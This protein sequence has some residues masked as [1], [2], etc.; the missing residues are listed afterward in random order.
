MHGPVFFIHFVQSLKRLLK[1]SLNEIE[2]SLLVFSDQVV[3]IWIR[4]AYSSSCRHHE[5]CDIVQKVKV[6][7]VEVLILSHN[8]VYFV[9]Y[10]LSSLD[11]ELDGILVLFISVCKE[12]YSHVFIISRRGISFSTHIDFESS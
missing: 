8:C 3:P 4:E 5:S 6:D 9:F 2:V 12:L 11:S 1:V 7:S 10:L